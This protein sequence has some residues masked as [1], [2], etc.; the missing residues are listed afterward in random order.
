[1]EQ[2]M[3]RC[4]VVTLAVLFLSMVALTGCQHLVID[5]AKILKSDVDLPEIVGIVAGFGTT[6]AAFPDLLAMLRRRSSEGMN[7]RMGAIMGAF[8]ILWVYYGLLIGSRPVIIWNVIAVL[9][10]FLTVGAYAYFLRLE[11]A[12]SL[13]TASGPHSGS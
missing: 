4:N 10:N 9:I 8:Q 1:M 6:F 11:K 12:R 13:N 5:T 2:L 7:P 3:S